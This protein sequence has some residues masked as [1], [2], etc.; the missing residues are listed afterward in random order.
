MKV[1]SKQT[2]VKVTETNTMKNT[3]RDLTW[4]RTANSEDKKKPGKLNIREDKEK[5]LDRTT[6]GCGEMIAKHKG[7]RSTSAN[8]DTKT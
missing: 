2:Q 6:S 1:K 3:R 7:T 8:V 5:S 4:T